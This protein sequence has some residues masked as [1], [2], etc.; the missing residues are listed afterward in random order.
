MIV[1]LPHVLC[2]AAQ[3]RKEAKGL[4]G[5]SWARLGPGRPLHTRA[6][7]QPTAHTGTCAGANRRPEIQG[8]SLLSFSQ[9]LTWTHQLCL[10]TLPPDIQGRT[11]PKRLPPDSIEVSRIPQHTTQPGVYTPTFGTHVSALS[12]GC[13]NKV[14]QTDTALCQ[15]PCGAKSLF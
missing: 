3:R 13:W 15:C 9:H 14:G 8:L 4:V 6:S 2:L 7:R 10:P 5:A 11:R 1:S 12:P